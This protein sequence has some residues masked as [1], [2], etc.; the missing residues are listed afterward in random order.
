[1][2][3]KLLKKITYKWHIKL[4]SLALAAILW[5]Y[6]D[7]LKAKER[8]LSVALEMRNMPADYIVSNDVP[9]TVKLVLKGKENGLALVDGERL[10]AYIDIGGTVRNR[11]RH[12]VRVDKESLPR[13]VTVKE[14]SPAFVETEIEAVQIKKARVVPVIYNEPPFGYQLENVEVIPE[15]V[16]IEGPISLVHDIDSVYTED[17][18]VSGLTETTIKDVAINLE[19]DKITLVDE[20][21]VTIKAIVK[22]EYVVRR[23]SEVPIV[24]INLKGGLLARSSITTASVLVKLPKRLEKDLDLDVVTAVVECGDVETVGRYHLPVLMETKMEGAS[25]INYEPRSVEVTVV[26]QE[27]S[28]INL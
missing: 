10:S 18:D 21:T 23:I 11:G 26:K 3:A 5:I 19:N 1:M 22:E 27:V 25:F 15:R 7:N 20:S 16:N 4:I 9:K 14:I 6:V 17:I 12:I 13:G 24:A 28:G 2:F 8:F